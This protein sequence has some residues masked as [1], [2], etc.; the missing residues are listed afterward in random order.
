MSQSFQLAAIM[1][2]DIAGYTALV[3][4][5]EQKALELL[6]KNRQLQRPII[7]RYNGRWLK[8]IGDGVLASFKSISDA[9]YAAGEIQ[10]LCENESD[11][12][13]RIGIHVGEVQ[14]DGDDV[15]GS[16]VNIA[17][18]L[19]S[20]APVGGI[21]VSGAVYKNIHNRKGVNATFIEEKTLKGVKEPV[22]TYQIKVD[23]NELFQRDD[24]AKKQLGQGPKR[25]E[26]QNKIVYSIGVA[27]VILLSYLIYNKIVKSEQSN[28]S[29]I[30]QL[31]KS[32]VVLPFENISNDP[33]QEYFV[34]GMM[35]EVINHLV[36]VG[37]LRVVPR[38]TAMTYQGSDKLNRE[39]AEELGVATILQG[40]VRKDSNRLRISI[41][42]IDGKTDAHLWSETYDRNYDDVFAIQSDVAMNIVASLQ[43]ELDPDVKLRIESEPTLALNA[44]DHYLKGNEAYW[45]SWADNDIEKVYESIAYFEKAI[46][47]DGQFSMAY[48]GIGRSYWWLAHFWYNDL[49]L[50]EIWR[51]SYESL[52][53]AIKIDPYNGWTYSELAVVTGNWLWDTTATNKNLEMAMKLTPSDENVYIHYIYHHSRLENCDNIEWALN[54]LQQINQQYKNQFS[55]HYLK[56]LRCRKNYQGLVAISDNWDISVNIGHNSAH[57]L[58]DACLHENRLEKAEEILD[59]RIENSLVKSIPLVNKALFA[60]AIGDYDMLKQTLEILEDISKEEKVPKVAYAAIKASQGDSESMY[61]YLN[62]AL[63]LRERELHNTVYFHQFNP[64]RDEPRFKDIVAR[65]WIPMDLNDLEK[66]Q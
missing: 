20:L 22:K 28:S 11:L 16:G 21:L 46:E 45:S 40:G 9:V 24:I 18:R 19:E 10:K 51:K 63:E 62:E 48:T 14:M 42:L 49:D 41:Q 13:I 3:D 65:M 7:E 64:Y 33:E 8:E 15:F 31:D 57:I 39:I 34:T 29:D 44:Y 50:P 58:F 4:K 35:D 52:A 38:S 26:A 27:I 12:K 30:E 53:K 36:K 17:S 25:I 56:L 1:F 32:I 60:A 54:K 5:D 47:L 6:K 55:Q 66:N 2:T 61:K 37:D 43:A 23:G 59:Y